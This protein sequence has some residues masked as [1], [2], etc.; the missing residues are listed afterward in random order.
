MYRTIIVDDE[1]WALVGMR[2]FLERGSD[3][4]QIIHETTNPLEAL[5][6]IRQLQ[7]DLVFT[8]I[9]MPELNGFELLEHARRDG[10]KT[11]FVIIS[12]F[13]EFSY[14]QQALCVGALD[15][16]LK[17]LD[18]ANAKDILGKLI[19]QLDARHL[20]DD[21][22]L[23]G[24]L[25][26]EQNDPR[27]LLQPRMGKPIMPFWQATTILLDREHSAVCVPFLPEDCHSLQTQ[28][29]PYKTI[30]LFNCQ[31]PHPEE[32]LSAIAQIPG[33]CSCG[34]SPVAKE[35]ELIAHLMRLCEVAVLDSFLH[36]KEKVFTFRAP[37]P[38]KV[39][40]LWKSLSSEL[41]SSQ[42]ES[43]K[44]FLQRLPEVFREQD[45]TANDALNLWNLIAENLHEYRPAT[46]ALSDIA[47]LHL[48][49]LVDKFG[50]FS[51][52]CQY[53][54]A[55]LAKRQLGREGSANQHFCRLLRYVDAHYMDSL[56]LQELCDQYYINVSYCCELFR[57]ETKSTFTQYITR[58]RMTHAKELLAATSLPLKDICDQVG[59]N[60]YF[61]FDKVFKKNV[62]CTPSEFRRSR[63]DKSS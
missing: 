27:A 9:R 24:W 14:A 52:M 61:Y 35:T 30:C 44:R 15:Y 55:Q 19:A 13:S 21:L 41:R 8:D 56:N 43:L 18:V 1:Q 31:Q 12:G 45:L 33:L 5:E 38:S 49:A 26:T 51:A 53:L 63:E 40:S 10:A 28:L 11:E 39:P 7:P 62:G 4:L 23:F 37:Q 29:G 60:D 58:L 25:N 2:K 22:S 57:R 36:P 54:I 59:Y 20:T 3:R 48:H 46:D 16:L 32:V 42:T 6:A 17:P 50:T 34:L 47:P